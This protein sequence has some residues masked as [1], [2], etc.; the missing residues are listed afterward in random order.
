MVVRILSKLFEE[1]CD[2]I[3]HIHEDPSPFTT[4]GWVVVFAIAWIIYA[5]GGM[6]GWW[7]LFGAH[8]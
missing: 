7:S 5:A 6:L 8:K 4:L 3:R 2:V 1:V